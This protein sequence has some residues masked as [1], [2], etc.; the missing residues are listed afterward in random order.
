M[1]DNVFESCDAVE[2]ELAG[3]ICTSANT[4]KHVGCLLV[5]LADLCCQIHSADRQKSCII[6]FKCC[7]K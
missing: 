6:V 3:C 5:L 2:E 1:Q 4:A 7:S